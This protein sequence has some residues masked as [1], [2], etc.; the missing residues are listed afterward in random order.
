VNQLWL[1]ILVSVNFGAVVAGH[2]Q[3]LRSTVSISS[4]DLFGENC[5]APDA[6]TRRIYINVS[7]EAINEK[8]KGTKRLHEIIVGQPK[9]TRRKRCCKTSRLRPNSW[10]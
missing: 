1:L 4:S 7:R 9:G 3:A 5:A 6:W 8:I 2:R 10:K